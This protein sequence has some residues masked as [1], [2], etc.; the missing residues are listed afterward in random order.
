LRQLPFGAQTL[1]H[2]GR[3]HFFFVENYFSQFI[4]HGGAFSS[5]F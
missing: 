2:D 4:G 1:V 5:R 3:L